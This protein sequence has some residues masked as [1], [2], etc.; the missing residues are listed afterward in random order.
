MATAKNEIFIG[1]W[2]ENFYLVGG[3]IENF[4]VLGRI[5]S[6]PQGFL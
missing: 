1:L 5:F 3:R 6:Y 2:F 4:K